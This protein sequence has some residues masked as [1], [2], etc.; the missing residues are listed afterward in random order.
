MKPTFQNLSESKQNKLIQIALAEFALQ[1]YET[2]SVTQI[3]KKA[4]IA[5]G[6]IYQYFENKKDLYF[7]LM[8][9]ATQKKQM[10]IADVFKQ[11]YQDFF[12]L[13]AKMYFAGTRFDL[14]N[15]LYSLFLYKVAQE[16]NSKDLG[17]LHQITVKQSTEY[18]KQLIKIEQTKG[19]LRENLDLDL[20]A[21]WVVQISSGVLDYLTLKYQ[22]DWVK[23]IEE[24]TPVS[25]IHDTDILFVF[26]FNICLWSCRE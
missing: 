21:F 19:N 14:Q 2:A 11:P 7:Y 9:Y 6:S 23:H 1:D 17:N 5:K 4:G 16:R 8:E 13:Y 20:T 18:F 26:C 15:P 10:V 3:V 24:N 25:I 12:D 22:I